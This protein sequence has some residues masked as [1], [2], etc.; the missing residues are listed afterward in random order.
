[1]NKDFH[2]ET[3]CGRDSTWLAILY[4]ASGEKVQRVKGFNSSFKM[5]INKYK[6][7]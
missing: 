3:L 1:M 2:C 7:T 5:M 4:L 6:I